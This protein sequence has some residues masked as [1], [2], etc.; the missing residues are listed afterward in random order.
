MNTPPEIR[1]V[2]PSF[3]NGYKVQPAR[4]FVD[5]A[6]WGRRFS[7]REAAVAHAETLWEET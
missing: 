2:P 4:W 1:Y 3:R 5:Q 6:G 7:S